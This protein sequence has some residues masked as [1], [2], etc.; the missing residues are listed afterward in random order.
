MESLAKLVTIIVTSLTALLAVPMIL[1]IQKRNPTIKW[2]WLW[3]VPVCVLLAFA[4][5]LAILNIATSF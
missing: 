1:F 5:A 2:H 3:I 4:A